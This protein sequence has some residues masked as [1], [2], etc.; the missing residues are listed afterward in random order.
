[1]AEKPDHETIARMHRFFAVECNNTAWDLADKADRTLDDD[2]Q[3]LYRA[4][5][6]AFHWT[7]SGS[8]LNDARSEITLAHVHAILGQGS[9][10]MQ[11]ARSALNYFEQ[12]DS[13]DWDI[14]FGHMELAFA[15]AVAGE[16]D[17][18]RQH[19]A[20]AKELGEAIVGQEDREIF[21]TMLAKIPLPTR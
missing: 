12:H 8:S 18:H 9:L 13:E 17:L 10:A 19:Y 11:Y 4:Y 7:Q 2:R 5:A 16:A 3:M 21:L 1:M 14:A 15:A 20:Q 6:S